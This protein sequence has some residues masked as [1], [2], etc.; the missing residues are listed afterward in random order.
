MRRFAGH[1]IDGNFQVG[2]GA[3]FQ[4]VNPA[5][6]F[7]TVFESRDGG[8][9][10]D[11]AVQAA[12]AASKS[13]RRLSF[14][15]RA[16][17]LTKVADRVEA[18]VEPIAKAIAMEMGK[19]ISESRVEARSIAGKIKG[20]IAN[21]PSELADAPSAAP[22]EQRFHPMGVMGII[23]PFNFP[24]HLL[25]T[26]VIPALIT[27]N[28]VVIKP[29][30]VTPL[31]GQLYAELFHEAGLP[32]GVFNLIQGEG[33]TGAAIST[34]ADIDALVFTGSYETGRR[35]RQATFDQP[36]KKVCLELGGKN[37]AL[38]LDDAHV[39]QTVRELLLGA[40][41]TTG[42]RCTA[43]SRLVITPKIADRLLTDLSKGLSKI[44]SGDPFDSKSFMGP[45]ATARSKASFKASLDGI[46]AEGAE[47]IAEGVEAA[48]SGAF[49]A[50]SLFRVSGK[51]TALREEFFGPNICVEVAAD[52]SDAFE[53]AS[54]NDYGLSASLF[55][56]RPEMLERFYDEVRVGVVN[57]NRSTNGASGLLPFGG[58]NKS[59]NWRPAGSVSPRLATYP[60]AVMQRAFGDMTAHPV[61]DGK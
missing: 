4:S 31:C 21:C 2:D 13:W 18:W 27:G 37:V 42:Q 19:S 46:R 50:P 32:N 17:A 10:V 28:T 59:G 7:E 61:L 41:L 33:G 39:E 23:G 43:T 35:I 9:F 22:G 54:R 60:V 56:S 47:V 40:F 26:H 30:E 25:N 36:W 48:G 8:A 29:S 49:V 51:E 11:D 58:T 1:Y 55:S 53:R 38:V 14:G 24:I 44:T 15:Q 52:E 3:S 34:H 6:G 12:R 16:N 57:F 45:L 20:V 5:K